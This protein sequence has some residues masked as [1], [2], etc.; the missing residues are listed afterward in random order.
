M[1]KLSQNLNLKLELRVGHDSI[2]ITGRAIKS[3]LHDML[4]TEMNGEAFLLFLGTRSTPD[5]L[6]F[7]TKQVF[8]Q[9]TTD[10]PFLPGSPGFKESLER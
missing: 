2:E 8:G 3:E 7:D 9:Q 6:L 1:P 10:V 4:Q 5:Y